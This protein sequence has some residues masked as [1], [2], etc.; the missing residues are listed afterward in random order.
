MKTVLVTLAVML[1]LVTAALP[2]SAGYVSPES[3]WVM[4]ALYSY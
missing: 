3:S 2:A 4:K 1:G